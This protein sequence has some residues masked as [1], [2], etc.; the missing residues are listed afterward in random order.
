MQIFAKTVTGKTITLDVEASDTIDNVNDNIQDKEGTQIASRCPEIP[1]TAQPI[2]CC[3]CESPIGEVDGYG[4][5][6]CDGGVL[7]L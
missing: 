2:W 1:T 4:V 5:I 6:G 7:S 3:R